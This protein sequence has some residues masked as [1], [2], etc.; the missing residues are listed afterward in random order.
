M[1][2]KEI[3][4]KYNFQDDR[5]QKKNSAKPSNYISRSLSKK[6]FFKNCFPFKQYKLYRKMML[7]TILSRIID[8]DYTGKRFSQ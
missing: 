6:T 2:I 4:Y 1:M 3:G 8:M 7:R 5:L